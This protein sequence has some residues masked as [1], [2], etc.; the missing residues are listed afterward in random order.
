M[1][2]GIGKYEGRLDKIGINFDLEWARGPVEYLGIHIG[3]SGSDLATLNYPVK[4]KKLQKVL[5]PWLKH[6]LTPFGR[7]HLIKTVAPS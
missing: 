5:N 2:C 3:P 7:I 4:I 1:P 6:G